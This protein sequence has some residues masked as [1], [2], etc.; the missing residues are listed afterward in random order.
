M[1]STG[2]EYRGQWD[3]SEMHGVG[4][5]ISSTHQTYAGNSA[6]G[7]A[8]GFGLASKTDGKQYQGNW[9]NDKP[10]GPCR[11]W[12]KGGWQNI[13]KG[14]ADIGTWQ[15]DDRGKHFYVNA[16]DFHVP[17]TVNAPSAVVDAIEASR[18]R[19]KF[20]CFG[21]HKLD[22]RKHHVS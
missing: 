6:R 20:N 13:S 11:V 9:K 2:A 19:T 22:T 16:N 4:R 5:Y 8:Q 15:T 7:R 17:W 21:S 1:G 3:H 12:I 10:F 14:L 18:S